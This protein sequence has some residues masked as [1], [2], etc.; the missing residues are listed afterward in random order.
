MEEETRYGVALRITHWMRDSQQIGSESP[1]GPPAQNPSRTWTMRVL[2][3]D[4]AISGAADRAVSDGV[5][6]EREAAAGCGIRAGGPADS[7]HQAPAAWARR[8]HWCPTTR[9]PQLHRSAQ[10]AITPGLDVEIA[11]PV[12]AMPR[13]AGAAPL[14][15]HLPA[16]RGM[17]KAGELDLG[18]G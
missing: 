11:R 17:H 15:N 12:V 14:R 18:L 4:V 10:R 3:G 6:R 13:P 9:S 2:H 8:A 16:F 7:P 1:A 5:G